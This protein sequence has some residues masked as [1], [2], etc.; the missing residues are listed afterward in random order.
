MPRT[1]VDLDA[2]VLRA[3]KRRAGREGKTMGEVA[4]ELLATA[5][6]RVT[7]P[8]PPPFAWGTRRMGAMVD[9]EDE[10]AVRRATEG[11]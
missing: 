6:E 11:P 1:T 7:E 3:L 9:L 4:S 2:A 10:E 8:S 5:L